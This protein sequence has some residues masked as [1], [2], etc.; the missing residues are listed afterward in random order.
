MGARMCRRGSPPPVRRISLRW[1]LLAKTSIARSPTT[2]W[3]RSRNGACSTTTT[4]TARY[5]YF[6]FVPGPAG[7]P[8]AHAS[9]QGS[10]DGTEKGPPLR[11][12]RR[13]DL[14]RPT[15]NV[16]RAFRLADK[17]ELKVLTT[18]Q[19]FTHAQSWKKRPTRSS[20][21]CI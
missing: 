20:E 6:G 1:S 3:N 2:S 4:S 5:A 12:Q 11:L 21:S 16:V 19:N 18:D 13:P 8:G 15:N 17:S 14:R 10:D 7:W 9:E